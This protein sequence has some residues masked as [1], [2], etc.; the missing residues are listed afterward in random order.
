MLKKTCLIANFECSSCACSSAT[1]STRHNGKEIPS[2]ITRNYVVS[3]RDIE[4][5]C[6]SHAGRFRVQ[7]VAGA[8][9]GS[10]RLCTNTDFQGGLRLRGNGLISAGVVGSAVGEEV[11]D[12]HAD[13]G[14]EQH[15]QAPKELVQRGA[16]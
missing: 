16:V 8:H 5:E 14:E 7:S 10:V 3:C 11:V 2:S 1:Q 12:E 4:P 6:H 15:N 13:E 9:I